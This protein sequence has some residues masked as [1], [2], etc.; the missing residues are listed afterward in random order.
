MRYVVVI[1]DEKM[2]EEYL[3]TILSILHPTFSWGRK[4]D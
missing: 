2:V 3:D 1:D 4:A